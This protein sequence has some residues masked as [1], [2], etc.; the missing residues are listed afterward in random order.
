VFKDRDK[1]VTGEHRFRRGYSRHNPRKMVRLW[2][3]KEMRNL[4]RL[5]SAGILCPEPVEVRENVLVMGFLGDKDGWYVVPLVHFYHNLDARRA[6]PRLKDAPISASSCEL[7]YTELVL[8]VRKMY[9]Q[10]K[11]VHADLSEYNILYH[12]SHLY[13]IDV[14]QSVEH[15]HPLAFDFLRNDIK[16][17]E[18]FFGRLGVK[19]LG[20]RRCFEFVTRE[21]VTEADETDSSVL[22][23]WLSEDVAKED[24]KDDQ[25]GAVDDATS[26]AAIAH[27][28]SVFLKSFIPR[29]L[30]EVKNPER[31]VAV[32][33]RGETKLIYADTIGVI[34]NSLVTP[35]SK[36]VRAQFEDD[37]ERES[38]DSDSDETGISDEEG[39]S[40]EPAKGGNVERKP[41]GHRHEDRDAK[42]VSF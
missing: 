7:L 38:E 30:N 18:D 36:V 41:R 21:K 15:D 26:S 17:I 39:E 31:D 35:G 5:F 10:C 6:F 24:L 11:L 27:E 32:L 23:R 34:P 9:H 40:G 1:Y 42:K 33:N 4:R 29:T 20:L 22:V 14:S 28:N 16:N 2:A 3:E 13:I 12:D 8:T 37:V 25:V 19:C